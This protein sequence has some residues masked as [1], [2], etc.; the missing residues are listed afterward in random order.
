MGTK[1]V[2]GTRGRRRLKEREAARR[3]MPRRG[4]GVG[5]LMEKEKTLYSRPARRFLMQSAS[6]GTPCDI[7][8]YAYGRHEDTENARAT[9]RSRGLSEER[10][11]VCCREHSF[12]PLSCC[13]P[14]SVSIPTSPRTCRPCATAQRSSDGHALRRARG[15]RR[16]GVRGAHFLLSKRRVFLLLLRRRRHRSRGREK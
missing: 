2:S 12:P 10:A 9:G 4:W 8:I 1:V 16:R 7:T 6:P 11:V 15:S 13:R 14:S 3:R 5:G